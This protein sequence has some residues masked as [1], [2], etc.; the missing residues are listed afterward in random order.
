M[1]REPKADRSDGDV[2]AGCPFFLDAGS[3][4]CVASSALIMGMPPPCANLRAHRGRCICGKAAYL[5][6]VSDV[7]DADIAEW[8]E[9]AVADRDANLILGR[10]N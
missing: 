6:A 2:F 10:T 8:V 3:R 7:G 9:K 5:A 4:S 1:R